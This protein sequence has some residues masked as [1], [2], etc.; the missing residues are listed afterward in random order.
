MPEQA[1]RINVTTRPS[2]LRRLWR[3]LLWLGLGFITCSIL[4]VLLFRFVPVPFSGVM[5]ERQV[6]AWW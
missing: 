3:G 2:L 1:T 5:L 4:L 6:S